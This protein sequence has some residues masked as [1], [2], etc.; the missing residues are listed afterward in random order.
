MAHRSL[1]ITTLL[2]ALYIVIL[3]CG[4]HQ[5]HYCCNDCATHHKCCHHTTLAKDATTTISEPFHCGSV[6]FTIE[7]SDIPSNF[8]LHLV[9]PFCTHFA[10]KSDVLVLPL[11][12]TV[13]SFNTHRPIL[14]HSGRRILSSIS[15][16]LI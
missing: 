11:T 7:E 3:G 9:L 1:H 8:N 4:I 14:P 13:H 12:K 15:L 16:L 10:Q 2:M 6:V 5:Y